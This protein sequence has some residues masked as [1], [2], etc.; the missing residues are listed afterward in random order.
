MEWHVRCPSNF[1]YTK[2]GL[3]I[4]VGKHEV[5][6]QPHGQRQEPSG[7]IFA[8]EGKFRCAASEDAKAAK[9][10]KVK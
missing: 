9:R 2:R 8:R 10:Q 7:C 5:G 1:R 6:Q 3:P 4:S